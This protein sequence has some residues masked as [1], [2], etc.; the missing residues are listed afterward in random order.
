MGNK[1]TFLGIYLD[2]L[3]AIHT[4]KSNNAYCTKIYS[5]VGTTISYGS[6]RLSELEEMG[7][8]NRIPHERDTRKIKLTLTSKGKKV[9][10]YV[11]EIKKCLIE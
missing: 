2:I 10:G 7:L 11:W 9:L 8:I 3:D 4:S 1:K 6:E 5:M